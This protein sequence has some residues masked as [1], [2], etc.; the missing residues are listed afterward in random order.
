MIRDEVWLGGEGE[1][2]K[3]IFLKALLSL[4]H[5]CLVFFNYEGKMPFFSRKK[6]SL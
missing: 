1:F 6:S 4:P 2:L 5:L 3:E